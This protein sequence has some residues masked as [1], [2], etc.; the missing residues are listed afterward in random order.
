MPRDSQDQFFRADARPRA[1]NINISVKLCLF[2]FLLASRAIVE[3]QTWPETF[4]FQG[5]RWG[6]TPDQVTEICPAARWNNESRKAEMLHCKID[7]VG[8]NANVSFEFAPKSPALGTVRVS[9]VSSLQQNPVPSAA[10]SYSDAVRL[11]ES[12]YGKPTTVNSH[13]GLD[14]IT[15]SSVNQEIHLK[16]VKPGVDVQFDG[17]M[18]YLFQ[19]IGGRMLTNRVC[20]GGNGQI[21]MKGPAPTSDAETSNPSPLPAS[22]DHTTAAMNQLLPNTMARLNRELDLTEGQSLR[23][24]AA[25]MDYERELVILHS[26]ETRS[27]NSSLGTAQSQ[28]E[29]FNNSRKGAYAKYVANMKSILS[30]AQ[31]TKFLSG[32]G[33]R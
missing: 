6:M 19:Y 26:L 33:S 18:F 4:P 17:E 7:G 12:T 28:V 27:G 10:F 2:V 21:I 8:T 30:T 9:F 29:N 3:A 25:F 24:K 15:S 14:P 23:V 31:F 20:S 32:E 5:V 11:L 1:V 13:R 16:W 22:R